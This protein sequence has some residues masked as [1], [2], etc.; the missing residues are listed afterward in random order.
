MPTDADKTVGRIKVEQA[1]RQARLRATQFYRE[2]IDGLAP[3]VQDAL[4]VYRQ[5]LTLNTDLFSEDPEAPTG[6]RGGRD[7]AGTLKLQGLRVQMQA[8]KTIIGTARQFMGKVNAP[9]DK[10]DDAEDE[11]QD[12][13][14]LQELRTRFGL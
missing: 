3:L 12:P 14:D 8:A 6:R 1:E 10:D 4:E 5:A 2:V 11:P 7:H 13:G 9:K